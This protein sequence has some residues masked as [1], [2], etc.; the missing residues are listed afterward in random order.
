MKELT[1]EIKYEL[2]QLGADV[3]KF[4]AIDELPDDVRNGLPV[5]ISVAVVYP[6]EVIRKIEELPTQEYCDWYEKFNERLDMIVSC[7]A[8][9]LQNMG[10]RA[11]AQTRK[12]VGFGENR[13]NTILPHKTI[14]TRA[15]I[16]WIGKCALLVTDKYGSAIRLS[17]ILTDAPL[18]TDSPINKS[19]C[20]ECMICSDACPGFAVSGKVWELGLY[21]DEF[22]DPV[23]CRK[24]ARNQ[25]K[26]GFGGEDITICGKC[27]AVCP[28]TQRYMNLK[29]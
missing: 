29:N 25:A 15:G 4:G 28:Y 18:S 2:K 27:I 8:E 20:G 6:K 24:T 7:G 26:L 1:Q 11:I 3:V 12:N 10:Y 9:L 17:S 19:K 13:D 16:G 22:F 5:G 21:R 23:K 14:A